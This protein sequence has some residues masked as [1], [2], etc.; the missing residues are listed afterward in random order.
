M[1]RHLIL[2]GALTCLAHGQTMVDFSAAATGG[3]AGAVAA[4]KVNDGASPIFG[5]LA[6]QLD[7]AAGD[8]PAKT[9]ATPVATA[10]AGG[11]GQAPTLDIGPGVSKGAPKKGT[12]PTS[13]G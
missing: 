1:I 11:S 13:G 3:T 4:K 10:Q 6:K 9:K 7:K 8:N 12:I 2:T 5:K